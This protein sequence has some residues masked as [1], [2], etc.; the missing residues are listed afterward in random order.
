M[1]DA[2]T[3]LTIREVACF[4]RVHRA[5]ISRLIQSGALGHIAIGSRK[6]VLKTDLQ[7]FI[8]NRRS[9]AANSPKGE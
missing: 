8:E 9:L 3:L 6:L 4:L 2:S 7:A 5:T 1:S